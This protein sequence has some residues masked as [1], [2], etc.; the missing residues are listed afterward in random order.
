MEI[1]AEFV[2][3]RPQPVA[4][5]SPANPVYGGVERLLVVRDDRLGD[6]VL[7]LPAV[8]RLRAAYGGARIGLLVAPGLS[9]LARMFRPV[10]E[11][12]ESGPDVVSTT[13]VIRAFRP[14]AAVCLSRRG[15]VVCALHRAGVR[16]ITGTGRRWFSFRFDRRVG[17]SRRRAMRHELEHA[18]DIAAC[19]GATHA[20]P[21]FP[22]DVPEDAT[23]RIDAW[24][25]RQG[26]DEAP[27]VIHPGTGGSCPPWPV[28]RW[29][30]L[31]RALR[32]VGRTVVVSVGPSEQAL[33]RTFGAE[34]FAVL[35]GSLPE[36][37]ALLA[38][39]RVVLSNSTGP[40]HLAAALD[41][42]TL[43]IHAPW[44][45]C[46]AER[47][48]PYSEHGWALVVRRP[49]S[50]RWSRRQRRRW[51]AE[52]MSGLGIETVGAA[53][54]ALLAGNSPLAAAPLHGW[55]PS[56]QGVHYQGS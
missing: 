4:P 55:P 32:S 9:A 22:L 44:R 12:L 54:E 20:A 52:G 27:I 43:A 24:L 36:L 28:N 5:A 37:A 3:V 51:A 7:S 45:S 41:R 18:L 40:I 30:E 14:D 33:S 25:G 15:S 23:E 8:E 10:D 19:A 38:R 46:S 13:T 39:S 48:A 42:P 50:R 21:R 34:E 6:L 35:D 11:V 31:A 26:I 53:V 49:G 2:Q 56:S 1:R 29:L 17:R 16:R 47:W